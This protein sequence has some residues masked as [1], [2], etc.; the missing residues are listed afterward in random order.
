MFSI[1]PVRFLNNCKSNMKPKVKYHDHLMRFVLAIIGAHVMVLYNDPQDFYEAVF[2]ASYVR[3]FIAS[4]II[5]YIIVYYIQ[6]ATITLDKKYDWQ[7]DTLL[8][9]IW[10][11]VFGIF[12][13]AF[14][15]FLLV[16]FFMWIYEINVFKT[17]Y[18]RQ[19]YPLAILMLLVL[20]L[21]YFGL[22]CFI[23][24]KS[25]TA[26]VDDIILNN[27]GMISSH[28][29]T[30]LQTNEEERDKLET[31]FKET[32]LVN[33]FDRTIPVDVTDIVYIFRYLGNVFI[34]L[35]S[36]ESINECYQVSFTLKELEAMLNPS[37]FFRINRQMII[38]R[39]CCAGYSSEKNKTLFI[40]LNPPLIKD[41]LSSQDYR[42]LPIVSEDRCTNFK[43]WLDR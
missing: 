11:L 7:A 22:Y 3:G 39:D 21:Y 30:F 28:A 36:M 42:K 12:V 41:G 34:R 8:R 20:N 31:N 29:G 16:A 38:S 17:S 5:S 33:T 23:K 43:F 1:K 10:Q 9:I 18:L 2:T 15:V 13:P 27:D 40:T 32:I 24:L 37:F 25:T 14:V 19:D 6:G 26:V 35:K 4:L